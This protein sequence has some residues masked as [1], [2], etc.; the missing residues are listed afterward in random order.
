MLR[1]WSSFVRDGCIVGTF[2]GESEGRCKL[3]CASLKRLH[4]WVDGVFDLGS[5]R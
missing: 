3:H 2:E 5:R 4:G 1:W